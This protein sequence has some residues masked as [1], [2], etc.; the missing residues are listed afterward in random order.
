VG[1][2][3]TLSFLTF[4]FLPLYFGFLTLTKPS[5]EKFDFILKMGIFLSSLSFFISTFFYPL[6]L[7][8]SFAQF[9]ILGIFLNLLSERKK[10]IFFGKN[11][12]W[13]F[14]LSFILVLISISFFLILALS[15]Q[16]FVAEIFYQRGLNFWRE[17]KIDRAIESLRRS[18]SL[19]P[20]FD[21][22]FRDL[23]QLYWVKADQK[24]QKGETNI[25]EE[26]SQSINFANFATQLNPINVINWSIRAFNYQNLVGIVQGAEDWAIRTW[27][28]AIELEPSNP[29][30]FTQKGIMLL[31]KGILSQ[32]TEEKNKLFAEAQENF[33]RAIELKSDYAPA[34]FQLAM[35]YYNQGKLD[36]AISK[37]EETKNI[38]PFDLGLAFQLGV[39]YYQKE[40][41][42]KA[43]EELERVILFEPNYANALYFLGLTYDK[44]GNKEKAIEKFKKV[45]ELNPD[46]EEV[47]KIISNLE[48]GKGALEGILQKVPPKVPIEEKLP[49]I[50]E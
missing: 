50:K 10:E 21:L 33:K 44:L 13:N 42:Q 29:Y 17:G 6:N 40:N 8:L 27:E 4:I 15:S 1:I 28:K 18:I 34:H 23:S 3:G 48:A 2:L 30:Y 36:E 14:S 16:R 12:L 20:N 26:V 39:A 46:V 49:E 45:A 5:F 7:T 32:N 9:F 31:R 43:K 37:M 11:P 25:Q 38:V 35:V 47:K 19:N 41:Y 22:Y 24:I